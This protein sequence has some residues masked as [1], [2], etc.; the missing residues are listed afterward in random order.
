[1][2]VVVVIISLIGT[3]IAMRRGKNRGGKPNKLQNPPNQQR[4][5]EW[6]YIFSI[7][8]SSAG[9][10]IYTF[11]IHYFI[12]IIHVLYSSLNLHTAPMN[13]KDVLT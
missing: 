1:M 8:A 9:I 3:V 12:S 11:F 10:N 13:I 5:K 7:D 4:P 2:V 6:K